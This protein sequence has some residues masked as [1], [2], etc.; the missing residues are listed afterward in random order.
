MTDGADTSVLFEDGD[1][2]DFVKQVSEHLEAGAHV[3][4]TV[5]PFEYVA[6]C[7]QV[8]RASQKDKVYFLKRLVD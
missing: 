8:W 3:K 5:S 4:R 1:D 2:P 7:R 6:T